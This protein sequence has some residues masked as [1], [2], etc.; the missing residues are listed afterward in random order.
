MKRGRV[1]ATEVCGYL[2]ISPTTFGQL[3]SAGVFERQPAGDGY[4][5]RV[6]VRACCAHWRRVAAGRAAEPAQERVLSAARARRETA[7]AKITELRLQRAKEDVLDADAVH[8]ALEEITIQL[9]QFLLWALPSRVAEILVRFGMSPD[10]ANVAHELTD[11]T[12]REALTAFAEGAE[13][14]TNPGKPRLRST[15]GGDD[16]LD[17]APAVL[18]DGD[19]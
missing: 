15:N 12:V 18:V 14:L 13:H 10:D 6:V 8:Y 16:G 1:T 17:A 7:I 19:V 9:R 4:D 11:D 5:L 3:A 2:D